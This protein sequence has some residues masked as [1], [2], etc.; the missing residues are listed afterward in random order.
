MTAAQLR[1]SLLLIQY[2][3]ALQLIA[4]R[5]PQR[6]HLTCKDIATEALTED[7]VTTDRIERLNNRRQA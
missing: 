3:V 7:F 5:D 6:G 2:R 4:N 1:A